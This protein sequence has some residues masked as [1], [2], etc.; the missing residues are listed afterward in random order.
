[1][2]SLDLNK[3]IKDGLSNVG[4]FSAENP[5]L[6]IIITTVLV[7]VSIFS[8]ISF[9][10]MQMGMNLYINE[11][12][13]TWKD[14]SD[15]KDEHNEGN[16][17]FVI[18]ESDN[19]YSPETIKTIDDLD[20][21]Y[22]SI[23]NV[24]QVTSISDIIKT[25]NG[26]IPKSEYEFKKAIENAK[27]SDRGKIVK[28]LIPRND[29]TLILASYG[30]VEMMEREGLLPKTGS[31]IIYSKFKSET[32][33]VEFPLGTTA[34]ITGQPVFENSAFGLMLPEMIMLFSGA[35]TLILLVMYLMM[36][37]RIHREWKVLLP[38]ITTLTA[39]LFMMGIM[40][41]LDYD[42]NAIMLGVMPIA[43]GLGI[44]YGLQIYTR[45]IE[46]RENGKNP[47]ES[48]S[49]STKT[50]G[51]ALLVAMGTTVIGLGSL[52]IS[53]VPP[54]RQFGVTS[55]SSVL[56]SMIL[57]ITLLPALLVRF[58]NIN[59]INE[60]KDKNSRKNPGNNR[61]SLESVFYNFINL[62]TNRSKIIL[63]LVLLVVAGGVFAYPQVE[64][65]QEMMDFWPQDLEAKNNLEF[66]EE[67]VESPK[68]FYV[69]AKSDNIYT[70]ES[71]RD[72]S[73]YQRIMLENPN[74]NSVIS[75]VSKVKMVN[76]KIP[77][78]QYRLN[79]ALSNLINKDTLEVQD[80]SI[81]PTQ[82]KM[83]FYVDDIEGKE[84]RV[85]IDEF[86]SN[87]NMVIPGKQVKV[88]GKQV[89]NRNVIENVTSGLTPMTVLSFTLG[90]IFLSLIFWSI[91]D[92][93][94]L[95]GGVATSATLMVAGSMYILKIP[96]NPLTIT[97]S[98]IALGIG[99]DYGVHVFERYREEVNKG[100]D[101]SEALSISVS[102]L[103]RPILASSL[104]TITGFGIL[105]FSR[106]P[107]LSNFGWTTVL[108]IFFSLVS[109][110]L[111]LPILLF[112][113]DNKNL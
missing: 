80:K 94:I 112:I 66:L 12:S 77:K 56:A 53:S 32:D 102:K 49:I 13:Q 78:N 87:A 43:L 1:M 29:L 23:D 97:M 10:Q 65:K 20:N 57:S 58:D 35:F 15:L 19:L 5:Q 8:A 73:E 93:T 40:G 52:L 44:D 89:L 9:I 60:K 107:V 62:S 70:P 30:D 46:E 26:E 50:T 24:D 103:S 98:S 39:L 59:Y 55:A 83:N 2:S 81:N 45:Y 51:R 22:S 11:D 99:I 109:A 69:I 37:H 61:N 25:E 91:R 27:S 106:F 42:F 47:I 38:L 34:T 3:I 48:A 4:K 104:T 82:I 36:R 76:G 41:I 68:V 108:T 113:F 110:F 7:I 33:F 14:W 54:V 111:I 101:I 84:S 72:I 28:N 90:L 31:E 105:I 64:T 95:V 63:G 74:V 92:S 85:L 86:K 21:R 75:P 96:W 71:F 16:N 67:N 88:T 79:K 17:I 18:I 100:K 6:I